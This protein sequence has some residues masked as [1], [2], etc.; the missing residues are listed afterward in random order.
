MCIWGRGDGL[1]QPASQTKLGSFHQNGNYMVIYRCRNLSCLF[2]CVFC[3]IPPPPPSPFEKG[4]I[5]RE[6]TW[7]KLA[8]LGDAKAILKSKTSNQALIHSHTHW[9]G[10]YRIKKMEKKKLVNVIC[11]QTSGF[12]TH[13]IQPLEYT[14]PSPTANVCHENPDFQLVRIMMMRVHL[15]LTTWSS[16]LKSEPQRP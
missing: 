2:R 11:T 7:N 16:S 6:K 10:R 4:L 12:W 13:K 9:Q 3:H 1:S 14:I 8:K 5:E 15:R